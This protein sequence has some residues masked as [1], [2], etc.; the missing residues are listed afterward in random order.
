MATLLPAGLPA[1]IENR[2]FDVLLSAEVPVATF[3]FDVLLSYTQTLMTYNSPSRQVIGSLDI[4]FDGIGNPPVHIDN[5]DYLIDMEVTEE[6]GADG[7]N[8]L[9]SISANELTFT[10]ANFNNLFSPANVASAYY[11]KI[12]LDVPVKA[13]LTLGQSGATPVLMGTFY[14]SE[15]DARLGDAVASV[16][17]VDAMQALLRMPIPNL[18]MQ[19]ATTYSA[20]LDYILT[21]YGLAATV[22][23]TLTSVLPYGAFS[24]DTTRELLRDATSAAMA[25]L[26]VDR[27]G[28]FVAK[29]FIASTPAATL[30]DDNQLISINVLQSI[31][32]T[33]DG[34]GIKYYLPQPSDDMHVLIVENLAIPGGTATHN[35]IRYIDPVF[36]ITAVTLDGKLDAHLDSYSSTNL[37]LAITTTSSVAGRVRL[38]VTGKSI[39]FVAQELLDTVGKILSVDNQYIQS[40][41]YAASYKALLDNYVSIENPTLDLTIRGNPEI[42]VGDTVVVQS[43]RYAIDYTGIVKRAVYRYDGG[44]S[45]NMT[46]LNAGVYA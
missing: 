44:L 33:Y 2:D 37:G 7:A 30:T 26:V 40:T 25:S 8:P 38:T 5:S 13:Y 29:R 6:L 46:L 14:V 11:G 15:W 1:E 18:D 19:V 12:K 20:F 35:P 22:D 24:V 9:G 42:V 41:E 32:R 27:S 28:Q 10:L 43:D 17:C 34:V 39:V 31:A 45:C 16:T 4:Y 21:G 3:D 36:N 23:S